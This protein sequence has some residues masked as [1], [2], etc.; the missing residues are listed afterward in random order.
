MSRTAADDGVSSY[1]ADSGEAYERFLGRWSKLLAPKL[2][3][4][5]SF[6]P[7]GPLLDVG[8]GTGSLACAM[9]ARWPARH[10]VGIDIAE[11][12]VEYARARAA[13]HRRLRNRNSGA[14]WESA[15]VMAADQFTQAGDDPAARYL[16]GG[17][18]LL[19]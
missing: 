9:A 12:Y 17:C 14:R 8:T 10:I 1:R 13:P 16:V 15:T 3:D 19:Q 18:P 5:A 4:F 11:A 2:L 7:A 6:Q